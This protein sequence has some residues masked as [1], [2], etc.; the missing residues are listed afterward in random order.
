MFESFQ[1]TH[2][3]YGYIF[4]PQDQSNIFAAMRFM[5]VSFW[6]RW[7]QFLEIPF[8]DYD[9]DFNSDRNFSIFRWVFNLSDYARR[10]SEFIGQ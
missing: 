8:Y 7:K 9:R 10:D 5:R 1:L 6:L 4:V 3:Q 2:L